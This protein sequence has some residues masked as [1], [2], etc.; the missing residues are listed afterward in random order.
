MNTGLQFV[1]MGHLQISVHIFGSNNPVNQ[2]KEDVDLAFISQSTHSCV[3]IGI[4]MQ[5]PP[6]T[7]QHSE[8]CL[9]SA[10][11]STIRTEQ[12]YFKA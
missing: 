6:L 7:S 2:P 11:A 4:C 9:A 3:T 12:I 1:S 5:T 8:P 10:I